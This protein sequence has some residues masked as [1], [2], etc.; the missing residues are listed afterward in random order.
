MPFQEF[1]KEAH[2]NEVPQ[3]RFTLRQW[4]TTDVTNRDQC[5][6]K[7][8]RSEDSGGLLSSAFKLS[9]V[10]KTFDCPNCHPESLKER[11][12]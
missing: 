7:L 6:T 4:M 12:G 11:Y 2:R 3:L 8:P 1:L 9:L 10:T 5:G